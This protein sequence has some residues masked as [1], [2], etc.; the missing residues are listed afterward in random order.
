[1]IRGVEVLAG[2][3]WY[4]QSDWIVLRAIELHSASPNRSFAYLD[5]TLLLF[6]L[7]FVP[8]SMGCQSARSESNVA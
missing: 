2:M 1:M 7:Y 5:F 4:V 3:K 6:F 8:H